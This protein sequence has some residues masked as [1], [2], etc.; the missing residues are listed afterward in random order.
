[1]T[2]PQLY[3]DFWKKQLPQIKSFFESDSYFQSIQLSENDF[4]AMGE[5][6]KYSFNLEYLNGSIYHNQDISAIARGLDTAINE[7]KEMRDLID[8]GHFNFKLT[9]KFVFKMSK[10]S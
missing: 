6:M 4:L 2:N 5:R 1:M 8:T 10:L 3:Q 7:N 9:S